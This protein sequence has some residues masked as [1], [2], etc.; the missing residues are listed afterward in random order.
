MITDYT[1]HLTFWWLLW[2]SLVAIN[3]WGVYGGDDDDD[4]T[5][6]LEDTPFADLDDF[7]PALFGALEIGTDGNDVLTTDDDT[8]TAMAG[9]EGNDSITGS[10]T[11]DY[12]LGNEGDDEIFA[13]VGIDTVRGGEGDDYVNAGLGTDSVYGGDGDDTLEGSGQNDL[14]DGGEGDDVLYGGLGPDSLVGGSGNDTLSSLTE[15][16]AAPRNASEAAEDGI[17]VLEGGDGDDE[18]WLAA[19]DIGTGGTGSDAFVADHRYDEQDGATVITDYDADDDE[20]SLLLD[21]TADGDTA[22]EVTQEDSSDGADRLILVNG[23]AVVRV[24]GAGGTDVSVTV[25]SDPETV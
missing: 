9:L 8:A 17:D 11:S 7:D 19:N 23:D 21:P 14:L 1:A 20:I 24:A 5:P 3:L 16:R 13:G 4:D 15:D 22:P 6:D 10:R 25:T 12:I 2:G 18:L